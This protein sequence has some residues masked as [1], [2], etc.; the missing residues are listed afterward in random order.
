M[1]GGGLGRL[2]GEVF[3]QQFREVVLAEE[4]AGVVRRLAARQKWSTFDALLLARNGPPQGRPDRCAA[5]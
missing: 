4:L 3:L 5:A 1:A 2:V